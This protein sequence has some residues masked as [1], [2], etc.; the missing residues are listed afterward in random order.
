MNSQSLDRFFENSSQQALH[1]YVKY[2]YFECE[3]GM[4]PDK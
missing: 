4:E 2:Q 1:N 3:Q